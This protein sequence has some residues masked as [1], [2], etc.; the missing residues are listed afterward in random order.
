[1]QWTIAF[2]HDQ[3]KSRE[4]ITAAIDEVI[5]GVRT[6]PVTL[7]ELRRAQT[8]IRA[9]LYATADPA[10][11]FGIVDLLAVGA[12]WENDPKWVN[13]LERGF[14]RVTPEL[15]MATAREYLRPT[16]RSILITEAGAAAPA[17]AA[18]TGASK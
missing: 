5:E 15:I 12:L 13:Q 6:R 1:M 8:K 17:A 14:A 7:Q 10:T 3:S 11:R 16:N 2:T 18:K 4:E 9:D